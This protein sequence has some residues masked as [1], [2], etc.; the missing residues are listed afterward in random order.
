MSLRVIILTGQSGSGKSTAVAALEDRGFYCVDN[1]PSTLVREFVNTVE[2]EQLSDRVVLVMDARGPHFADIAPG[3]IKELRAGN[4]QISLVFFEASEDW[5]VRRYTETRRRHPLDDDCGLQEAIARERDVLVPFRE[6]SDDTVDTSGM[7]PH[8]LRDMVTK[9]YAG[10]DGAHEHRLRVELLSFGFK[11]GVPLGADMVFDVRFLPNPYFVTSMR[12]QT[13]LDPEVFE[14]VTKAEQSQNFMT[15]LVD[16][17]EFLLPRFRAEGKHYLTVAVGC[18]GGRHRSVAM[19]RKLGDL[20]SNA[21]CDL[22][23][24]HRDVE[25]RL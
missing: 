17:A 4:H 12:A 21:E 2:A 3:T 24:R 7:S 18:T 23:V 16:M 22:V 6:L 1:M 10:L 25:R 19:V 9:R 15:R 11:H 8:E 5:L 20:L 13:G 14:Y